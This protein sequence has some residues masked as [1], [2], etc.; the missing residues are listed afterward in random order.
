MRRVEP[1]RAKNEGEGK[2]RDQGRKE[3]T[4]AKAS[5][6]RRNGH[7]HTRR[8]YQPAKLTETAQWGQE[9]P[10]RSESTRSSI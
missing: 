6:W 8:K 2:N 1:S 3:A 5:K 4:D 9:R 7:V 10:E